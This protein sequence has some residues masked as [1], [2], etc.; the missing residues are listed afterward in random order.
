[1]IENMRYKCQ[2][3]FTEIVQPVRKRF[4]FL[5]LIFEIL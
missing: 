5:N 3:T 1:M 2:I 4:Y